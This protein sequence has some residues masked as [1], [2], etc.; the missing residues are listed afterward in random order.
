MNEHLAALAFFGLLVLIFDATV[1]YAL[2]YAEGERN[3]ADRE[4]MAE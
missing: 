2:L 1:V 4:A 3:A